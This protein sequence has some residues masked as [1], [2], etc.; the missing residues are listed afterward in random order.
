MVLPRSEY[1]DSKR[2][3]PSMNKFI[4]N[5]INWLAKKGEVKIASDK[6][7]P[8]SKYTETM[9]EVP[10]KDLASNKEVNVY[11]VDALANVD[12]ESV[13][14]LQDFVKKGGGLLVAGHCYP[15]A[16]NNL[17]PSDLPGNK[18]CFFPLSL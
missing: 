18:Y 8:L 9:K 13:K 2:S 14:L 1:I 12:E 10:Q 6:K 3:S 15:C 7:I 4:E 16:Y 11:Y 17:R 5:A